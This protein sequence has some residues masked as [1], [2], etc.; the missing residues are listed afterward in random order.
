MNLRRWIVVGSVVVIG[1]VALTGVPA[2]AHHSA[3]PFY[4]ATKRVAAIKQ[5]HRGYHVLEEI[6]VRP[7]ITYLAKV[8]HS[9]EA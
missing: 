9:V 5:D 4:D 6:N 8:L 2:I 1:L 3:A 7:A